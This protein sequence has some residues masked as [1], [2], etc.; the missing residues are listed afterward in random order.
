[1]DQGTTWLERILVAESDGM[2]F[3]NCFFWDTWYS[4]QQ[5]SLVELRKPAIG[6]RWVSDT[7]INDRRLR[8]PII[9]DDCIGFDRKD[10]DVSGMESVYGDYA[11]DLR[12]GPIGHNFDRQVIS[13][14]NYVSGEKYEAFVFE[15]DIGNM[16]QNYYGSISFEMP[17]YIAT[18]RSARYTLSLGIN[19]QYETS[20]SRL[21]YEGDAVS[22][23]PGV[24]SGCN[25]YLDWVTKTG[26]IIKG[27]IVFDQAAIASTPAYMPI[28]IGQPWISA[29]DNLTR[30][31]RI[32]I[33]PA[34]IP[35]N[36]GFSGS[37]VALFNTLDDIPAGT[38]DTKLGE[39]Q[40]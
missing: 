12:T 25:F 3:R 40:L 10:V 14:S 17:V 20:T 15:F 7:T 37:Q 28:R 2:V 22:L 29:G 9:F 33:K 4:S 31:A 16:A 34:M 36:V 1:V 23:F 8:P 24:L 38:R 39:I 19:L 13:I 26:D 11:I 6:D 5:G 21:L 27:S 30:S 32:S 18:R 35:R